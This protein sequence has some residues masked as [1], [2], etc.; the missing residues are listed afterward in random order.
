M[1]MTMMM[2]MVV[3]MGNAIIIYAFFIRMMRSVF[4][5]LGDCE[6]ALKVLPHLKTVTNRQYD[7]LDS[8]DKNLK[9][10]DELAICWFE[11]LCDHFCGREGPRQ[12]KS[13]LERGSVFFTN[14]SIRSFVRCPELSGEFV[15][16]AWQIVSESHPCL[17]FPPPCGNSL[18]WENWHLL[19]SRG[20]KLPWIMQ[21]EAKSVLF[22]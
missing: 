16:K 15:E 3:V 4:Q 17:I 1:M 13:A 6:W 7:D 2:A 18:N 11:Q 14:N 20:G 12:V 22:L 10:C 21:L 19:Y 8:I 5:W 9:V